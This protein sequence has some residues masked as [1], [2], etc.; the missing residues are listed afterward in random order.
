MSG[1]ET[2]MSF[3][4]ALAGLEAS[5]KALSR[6]EGALSEAIAQYE[7]GMEYYRICSAVLSD[8][9]QKIER[10]DRESGELQDF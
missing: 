8:A 1:K 6:D 9:R 10:F 4:E 7:K 5:V 3:E 2:E